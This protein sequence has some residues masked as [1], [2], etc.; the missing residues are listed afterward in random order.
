MMSS[1]LRAIAVA[2]AFILCVIVPARADQ[3]DDYVER[4]LREL[5]IPGLSLAVVRNGTIIKARGYGLANVEGNVPSTKDT[6][7]EIGSMTKQFTATAVMMLVEEGKVSLDDKITKYFPVAPE[8]W[9][10]ITI[11]HLLTHTSGIQNHVAVPD[12]PNL[13]QT[14]LTRDQLIELFFKLPLEFQPGETW[15]YDNTGYYLLGII[16]EK[17]SGKSFWQF[18]DERIF[19]PVGMTSTRN[20]DAQP[21]VTNRASGYE[22]VNDRFEHRPVLAPFI[23]FS[24]GAI[25]SNVEDMARW[26][27]ALYT[28]R[29]LKRSSLEQ[30]W[31]PAKTNQD[32]LASFD[33]GYGWFIDTYHGHRVVQHSG[34][35]PG[36][37]SIIYRFVGDQLTVIILTNHADRIVDQLAIDIAG[38]YVPALARPQGSLDPDPQTSLR[39]KEVLT[40]LLKGKHDPALFTPAMATFLSTATGKAFWKWFACHG[41][42]GSFTYSDREDAGNTHIFRYRLLL[43]ENAYWFS[44]TTGEGGRIA[45]VSFW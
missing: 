38:M 10:R 20:T 25:L 15:A 16:V 2:A 31:T 35:T 9:S 19:R 26:D 34:G 30:M 17:A 3:V 12:F 37:S 6:V 1:H 23:A 4:Q 45:R 14:N 11:R 41:A 27:A 42:L 32:A 22:W 8:T 29:L 39:L 7:Y 40:G 13:F 44:V 5:H 43:G 28:E 33:Y 36:F 24:A 21:I 18:L